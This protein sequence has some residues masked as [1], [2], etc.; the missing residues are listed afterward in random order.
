MTGGAGDAQREI[1][2]RERGPG[3]GFCSKMATKPKSD[4]KAPAFVAKLAKKHGVTE[5]AV[6]ELY[7]ALR[8]GRGSMAQFSHPELGGSGQWMSGGMLMIGDMFNDSLRA[9]VD[10]ICRDLLPQLEAN[11]GTGISPLKRSGSP[12]L[13]SWWPSTYPAPAATGGQNEFRYAYF[14]TK[15]VLVVEE[16]GRREVYDTTG[17]EFHGFGQQQPSSTGLSIRSANGEV[18]LA[19]LPRKVE[20]GKKDGRKV[21]G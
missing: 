10:A 5:A 15:N 3:L 20:S 21:K 19:K 6:A 4:D 12:E 17:H 18:P 1:E 16:K 11:T 2:P 7:A 14:P 13:E 8:R 9:K